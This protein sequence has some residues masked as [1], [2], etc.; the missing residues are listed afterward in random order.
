[1]AHD[2]ECKIS[3]NL[4]LEAAHRLFAYDKVPLAL[5]LIYIVLEQY[6]AHET[7]RKH[8]QLF[9]GKPAPALPVNRNHRI[10]HDAETDTV[11]V[12]DKISGSTVSFKTFEE[13][14]AY[15]HGLK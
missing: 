15:V 6:P 2:L 4:L 10:Y 13:A 7:A 9:T 8:Y 5:T 3:V 12:A 1:M 14:E 11:I